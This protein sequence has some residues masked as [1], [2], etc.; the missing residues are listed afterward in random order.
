MARD[1]ERGGQSEVQEY[2]GSPLL[3]DGRRF[4]IGI[5]F[6]PLSIEPLSVWVH[7]E[8][9]LVLVATTPWSPGTATA[10]VTT[11]H[12]TNGI[13]NKRQ[14]KLYNSSEQVW[15]LERLRGYVGHDMVKHIETGTNDP[16]QDFRRLAGRMAGSIKGEGNMEQPRSDTFEWTSW[17]TKV[18]RR[19]SLK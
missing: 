9:W 4:T 7:E 2:I 8:E 1:P 19:G 13:L 10:N 11:M 18:E 3:L 17:L 14:S 6:A 5:Y 15:S 12:L 16:L